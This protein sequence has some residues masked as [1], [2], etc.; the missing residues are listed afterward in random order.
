MGTEDNKAIIRRIGEEFWNQGKTEV[1]D[2]VFAADAV[3]HNAA[4][5]QPP[6]REGIKLVNLGFRVAMPDMQLTVDDV[7]AEDDKVVWR[8]TAQ[9]THRGELMG[10]PPTGRRATI[11]GISIDRFADGRI[12]ER[13][14]QMDMLGLLQQ[15][16]AIPAPGQNTG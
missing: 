16:G 12:V 2:E 5:G 4:P 8:W 15:L 3:D 11:S 14:L 13:W 7:V 6:G 9:G 1:L 10:I